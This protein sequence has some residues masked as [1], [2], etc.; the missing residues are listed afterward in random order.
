MTTTPNLLYSDVEDQLRAS[1]RDL[2]A[3]RSPA[4]TVLARCESESWYDTELWR[5]LAAQVGVVGLL[6]HDLDETGGTAREV[7]VVMEELGASLAP[8]PFLGSAVLATT[9][10]RN[11]PAADDTLAAL[12]AGNCVGTLAIPLSTA[13]N[14][15]FP[16]TVT[17]ISDTLD[18]RVT[19]VVDLPIADVIVVP[20]LGPDGPE[21]HL[22]DTTAPGVHITPVTTLDLTRRLADLDLTE[23]SARIVAGPDLA[24]S[25]LQT[26]LSTGA[27]LLASEQVGLSERCLTSTVEYT[28]TRIQFGRPIGSFQAVRHRLADAWIEVV[29]ARAAARAAADAIA[30]AAPDSPLL[31][32]L[33]QAHCST[34]AVSAAE[35]MI[36]LHGGIGM[37]WEHPTHLYLGRAKSAALSLGTP[38]EH[39]RQLAVHAGLPT[40]NPRPPSQRP[41]SDGGV[42]RHLP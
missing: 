41:P 8:V 4:S 36:Q 25:S 3:V 5:T 24:E 39:R 23:V 1:V 37:T 19:S 26:A 13:P 2:L 34:V 32:A 11:L 15:P 33:A 7:A 35:T 21:L 40:P 9:A 10:L 16:T 38:A 18:G 30:T 29:S 14:Q 12:A 28:R 27:A 6:A 17:R 42:P 20:A 22:I 31:T